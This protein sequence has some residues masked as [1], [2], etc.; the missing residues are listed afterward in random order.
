M[1]KFCTNCGTMITGGD[2]FCRNCGTEVEINLNNEELNELNNVELSDDIIVTTTGVKLNMTEIINDNDGSKVGSIKDV[3][4]LAG[5]SLKEAKKI[6]DDA[7]DRVGLTKIND[8]KSFKEKQRELS[9]NKMKKKANLFLVFIILD[10]TYLL[11]SLI[12]LLENFAGWSVANKIAGL[13]MFLGFMWLDIYL[14]K[15]YRFYK[16]DE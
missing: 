13:I 15:K 1:N 14:L 5:I 10:T 12:T 16:G 7:Y 9:I 3:R 4:I 8:C 11:L 6:V 2:K